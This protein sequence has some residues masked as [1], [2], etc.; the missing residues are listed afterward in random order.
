MMTSKYDRQISLWVKNR[1]LFNST[2]TAA[3]ALWYEK[4]GET[5]T[6]SEI[7]LKALTY[8]TNTLSGKVKNDNSGQNI[9]KYRRTGISPE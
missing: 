1:E 2:I 9:H 5:L 3:I 4:F 6:K 7:L 8:L